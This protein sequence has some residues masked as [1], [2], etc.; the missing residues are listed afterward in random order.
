[1]SAAGLR[2]MLLALV[3]C[4]IGWAIFVATIVAVAR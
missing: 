2:S 3:L 4:A 1:M